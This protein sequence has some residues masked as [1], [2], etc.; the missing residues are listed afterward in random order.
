MK[1]RYLFVGGSCNGRIEVLDDTIFSAGWAIEVPV[2]EPPSA[3]WMVPADTPDVTC[4][5]QIYRWNGH[6]TARGERV[7]FTGAPIP[8]SSGYDRPEALGRYA[9]KGAYARDLL[10]R[11]VA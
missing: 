1:R 4:M 10:R 6:V 7:L 2:M 11:P 9:S 5:I 8:P 3:R